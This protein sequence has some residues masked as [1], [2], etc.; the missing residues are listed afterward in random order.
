PMV[1]ELA[2]E[3]LRTCQRL[4][5]KSSMPRLNPAIGVGISCKGWGPRH[6]DAVY[7][8][9]VP[10]QAPRGHAFHLELAS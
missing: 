7:R 4:H 1:Q 10:L 8:L 6:D 3:L 9:L 5:R 2:D